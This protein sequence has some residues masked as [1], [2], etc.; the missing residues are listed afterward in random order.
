MK[1]TVVVM[2]GDGIGPVVVREALRVLDAAGFEASYVHG[3]IGWQLWCSEGDPLPE[4]TVEL[5]Q[6][7]RL[8]LLGAVTSKPKHQAQAELAEPLRRQGLVYRSA[9]LA[10]R[11]RLGLDVA[12]RPSRTF[13]GNPLN[14]VRRRGEGLEEP[15]LDTTV[16][17]QNT[18]CLYSGVEWGPLPDGVRRALDAHPQMRPFDAVA[19]S[20]LAVSARVLSRGACERAARAAFALARRSG[21]DTV[22]LCDK[23]G[24][25]R[26]TGALFL[27]AAQTVAAGFPG[28]A[29]ETT[30]I[31]AQVMW[32]TQKPERFRVVLASALVGDI[33]SDGFAGLVGGLGFAHAANLAEGCAVFEP[34]H[35][36]APKYAELEPAIVNPL[37]AILAAAML[38]EHTGDAQCAERIRRAV[39]EVVRDGRVRTFDLLRLPGGPDVVSRGAATTAQM[40][41]AVIARLR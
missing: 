5:L 27:E 24:V 38:V 34:V 4:A 30:N 33:L 31:D 10:L 16:V 41:D 22:T 25:M 3:D 36:S 21:A 23:W 17:M 35:G 7:H 13:E 39:R 29:L 37:A 11:Q 9:V 8:G 14:F 12:L 18:E 20:D 1:P 32:L 15:T 6:R 28:I 19:S 26:E 2:P 40:T